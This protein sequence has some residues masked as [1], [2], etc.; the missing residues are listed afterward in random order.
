M[1]RNIVK[2]CIILAFVTLFSLLAVDIHVNAER[3][4]ELDNIVLSGNFATDTNSDGVSDNWILSGTG[5]TYD[6]YENKQFISS[7]LGVLNAYVGV[8]TNLSKVH[9]DNH[10]YYVTYQHYSDKATISR[11]TAYNI[12]TAQQT[13]KSNNIVVGLNNISFLITPNHDFDRFYIQFEIS[14]SYVINTYLKNVMVFDLTDI[15]GFGSE[16]SLSDFELYYL[17]DLDYFDEYNSFEPDLYTQ[18]VGSDYTNLGEDLT[19]LDYTKSIIDND[20]KNIDLDLYLYFYDTV[21][22]DTTISGIYTAI[23]Y[24]NLNHPTMLYNG[25]EYTLDWVFS[26]Y[27]ERVIYLDLSSEEELILKKILFNRH[28][29]TDQ[30]YFEFVTSAGFL[31]Y[32]KMWFSLGSKFDLLVDVESFMISRSTTTDNEFNVTNYMYIK[33]YDQDDNLFLPALSL[34]IG[35]SFRTMYIDDFGSSYTN[36]SRFNFEFEIVTP[37]ND[38]DYNYETQYFYEIGI[39]SSDKVL[40]PAYI[41]SDLD[42]LWEMKT[43]DWYQ[44]GC[45]LSNFLNTVLTTVYNR[46][47]IDAILAFFQGIF[48]DVAQVVDILPSGV[49]TVFVV[50][51]SGIGVAII[52]V[53]IERMNR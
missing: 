16:P 15:F 13:L 38:D 50:L 34:S 3:L 45:H 5:A 51:F 4:Y 26:D 49:V 8:R 27:S 42:S 48:E 52:I 12:S 14:T 32:A 1:N 18:L 19:G 33:V 10:I 11:L 43:C 7:P 6:N 20:G 29:D 44:F 2:K 30:E 46:L 37:G 31:S 22:N 24:V 53:I 36:I 39:F 21:V 40:H 17:P 23:D 9:D 25:I 41:D 35:N 47:N 28:I